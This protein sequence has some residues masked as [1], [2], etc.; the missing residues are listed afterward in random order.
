VR[1]D[2]SITLVIGSDRRPAAEIRSGVGGFC[3]A[4]PVT[5]ATLSSP[6]ADGAVLVV[7]ADRTPVEKA[8]AQ[9]IADGFGPETFLWI[10]VF[11]PDGGVRV[12]WA[13]TAGGDVLGDA[14][15]RA[16][17]AGA[18]DCADWF[19]IL[20]RHV[21]V[22]H[23]G[24]IR[25]QSYPL[26]PVR[27]DVVAGVRGPDELRGKLRRIVEIA[28]EMKGG[29]PPV[30]GSSGPLAPWTGVGPALL[31]GGPLGR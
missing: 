23:R 28:T 4:G 10:D 2:K 17:I 27:D 22:H 16:A 13:W 1:H 7:S 26:P 3:E 29:V 25:I 12:W 6:A 24:R 30:T 15:D 11:Q 20:D 8:V 31:A 14:V 21:S 18:L 5:A 9:S 19:H